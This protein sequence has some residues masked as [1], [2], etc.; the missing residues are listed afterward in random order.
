MHLIICSKAA[1]TSP[2]VLIY[3]PSF[4]PGGIAITIPQPGVA[5][6][7]ICEANLGK[8]RVEEVKSCL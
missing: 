1:H 7:Y 3:E 8:T 5:S 4:V 2:A 6:V